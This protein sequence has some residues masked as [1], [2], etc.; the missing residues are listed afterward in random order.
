MSDKF[1]LTWKSGSL[2]LHKCRVMGVLNITPDS[3]YDGGDFVDPSEAVER[4]WSMVDEGADLIDIGAESTRPGAPEIPLDDE[5]KRLYPVLE[6]LKEEN[7]PLPISVDTSKPEIIVE[8][9]KNDL[10]QIANDITG[11]RNP[12]MVLAVVTHQIP[13]IIMHMFG[14]PQTM[15]DD[16]E[17]EDVVTD[18]IDFFKRRLNDCRLK[19]NVVLDPGIG[20]GKSVAHN[21]ALLNR[22]NEFQS[23]GFPLLVGASRK[24]FIGKTLDLEVD[25]RLEGSLAAA[26]ISVDRGAKMLRV[27]D[28]KETVRVVRM[29]EA[30][31]NST[32]KLD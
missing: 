12:A 14:T 5:K 21:L 9:C 31:K 2:S 13:V 8:A 4:A 6:K 28:V 1:T 17:Y 26:A 3:F 29:V 32:P 22:L 11:L 16:Y 30:I 24:S 20:F 27:H 18:I 23:L 7:F 25:E 10:I 19:H 15:Q